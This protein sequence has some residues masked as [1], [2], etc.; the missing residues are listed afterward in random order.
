MLRCLKGLPP[1]AIVVLHASC[2]NPTGLDLDDGQWSAVL[3]TVSTRGLVPF[4]DFAYQG[5]AEGIDVDAAAVRQFAR[6][7]SPVFVSSSFSKSFSLYGERV[8]A[9]SVIGSS[10]DEAA[11]VLSQLKRL[12]RTNYSNPPTHGGQIVATVLNTP[13]LR[14][15]WEKELSGMRDRIRDM[16]RQLV[17][18]LRQ[19][20]PGA[21]FSFVERQRGMFSYSGLTKAQVTRLREEFSVYAI[22]TG[23]ICVAA[24]N[25]R[26]IDY[27]AE[28]IGKVV[29]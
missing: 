4:L 13:E 2:H 3:E 9:L 15:I 23:R 16:R 27:I 10:S 12:I 29:A 20:A 5:F 26:N 14:A 24:I 6:A 18:K 25:S 1:G 21:E 28:A 8:G 17:E 11:R 22:D 7:T 19:Q